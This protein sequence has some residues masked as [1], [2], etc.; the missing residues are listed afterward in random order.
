MPSP[1]PHTTT[2][3]AVERVGRGRRPDRTA[4]VVATTA[5]DSSGPER[6]EQAAA[7]QQEGAAIVLPP[8]G[9]PQTHRAHTAPTA[10]GS[11]SSH[12]NSISMCNTAG[13]TGGCGHEQHQQGSGHHQQQQQQQASDGGRGVSMLTHTPPC[14]YEDQAAA[15]TSQ[16]LCVCVCLAGGYLFSGVGAGGRTGKIARRSPAPDKNYV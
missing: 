15:G 8:F 14:R 5:A 1:N 16:V 3:T 11:S 7:S 4:T 6:R 9:P 10:S 13:F 2:Q 12:S